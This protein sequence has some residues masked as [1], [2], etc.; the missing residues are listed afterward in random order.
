MKTR[1]A[2]LHVLLALLLGFVPD[3][4]A[5]DCRGRIK[6]EKI[7]VTTTAGNGQQHACLNTDRPEVTVITVEVPPGAETGWHLHTVPVYAYVLAEA[8][9][10]EL[11]D[12]TDLVFGA[13]EAVVEMQN[14]AHNGKNQGSKTVRPAVFYTGEEGRANVTRLE[15]I[16]RLTVDGYPVQAEVVSSEAA[17]LQGLMLRPELG[18]NQGMLFDYGASLAVCMWMKDTLIPLAV[19]FVDAAGVIVNIE[20]MQ[21][22]TTDSHCAEKEVRYALEMNRGWFARRKIKPGSRIE[23]LSK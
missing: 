8:L 6:V 7:L 12:G 19:A 3:L 15:P 2:V 1:P 23:G 18:E 9:A 11:V 17:L 16:L 10:V 22:E 20:E 13:G 5:D 21:P 14:L 4:R